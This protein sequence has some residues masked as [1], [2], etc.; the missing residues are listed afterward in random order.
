M[1]VGQ[2]PYAYANRC[3]SI[4]EDK[5]VHVN[6]QMLFTLCNVTCYI[7]AIAIVAFQF[8]KDYAIAEQGLPKM[9]TFL[10]LE[11]HHINCF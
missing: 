5:V 6:C 9:A 10:L 7:V 4:G 1:G 2:N 8:M 11:D 3:N